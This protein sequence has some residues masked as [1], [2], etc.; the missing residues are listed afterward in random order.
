MNNLD[1]KCNW[2]GL[3]FDKKYS[4]WLND[5]T[6]FDYYTRLKELAINMFEWVNLPPT[7]DPRFL[8][9]ILFEFGYCLFFQHNVNGAFLTLQCAINGPLNMYRIPIRRRAYAVTGFNQECSDQDSVIIFNNYLRQ[10]TSLTVELFAQRLTRLERAIDVNINAQKTPI[11]ITGTQAQKKS[12]EELYKKF[13]ENAP[14]IFGYKGT[15][16]TPLTVFK[17]DAPESYPN[18]MEAKAR[19]WNEALTFLG[20]NNANTDKRERLITDEVNSN[21]QLLSAQ[22]YVMLNARKQACDLI[23]QLFATELDAPVDVRFREGMVNEGGDKN[24]GFYDGSSDGVRSVSGDGG[25]R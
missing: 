5:A 9:L 10:P 22:R 6:F 25:T 7:C 3:R 19:I 21:N 24:V 2:S 8:E 4:Q 15:M 12:M 14:V 11:L 23:N 17:T 20:V 1:T 13:D 18:L 16:D